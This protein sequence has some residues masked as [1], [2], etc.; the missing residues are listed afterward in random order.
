MVSPILDEKNES[1]EETF[2]GIY[3]LTPE[4]IPRRIF[5]EQFLQKKIMKE[6][7]HELM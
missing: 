7:K 3:E 6:Y 4:E 1:F 5:L 2:G